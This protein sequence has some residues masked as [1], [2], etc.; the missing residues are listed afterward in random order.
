ME[1]VA[2]GTNK[3]VTK[4]YSKRKTP[5]SASNP[6]QRPPKRPRTESSDDLPLSPP[7]SDDPKSVKKPPSTI[8]GYF[9]S[10]T[11]ASSGTR[12]P[13]TSSDRVFS[14]GGKVGSPP[15]S[16][17]ARRWTSPRK[18][19]FRPSLLPISGNEEGDGAKGEEAGGKRRS[20]GDGSGTF[21][22]MGDTQQ[23]RCEIDVSRS[24]NLEA[25][26]CAS[27]RPGELGPNSDVKRRRRS[28]TNDGENE[29]DTESPSSDGAAGG[30]STAI[31]QAPIHGSQQVG[32]VKTT[33]TTCHDAG[34]LDDSV[35]TYT[36]PYSFYV[37]QANSEPRLSLPP[38]ATAKKKKPTHTIQTTLNLSTK[39]PFKEC[40]LCDTVYN[41]LH[42]ADVKLHQLRHARLLGEKE[43]EGKKKGRG[44]RKG[45]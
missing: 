30:H 15:S 1:T 12:G 39:Q 7:A 21:S 5:G 26:G 35:P 36:M 10:S 8:D 23:S 28:S 19:K 43:G 27:V 42:A 6:S 44:G 38:T 25:T 31:P 41:P 22:K 4:T 11:S 14:E 33:V 13:D 34:N 2:Q 24:G 20:G 18:L 9:F 29:E 16:P 32:T 45:V 40:K 37:K 17:P 3:R